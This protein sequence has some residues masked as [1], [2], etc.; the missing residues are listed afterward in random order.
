[1][2]T[3]E[4]LGSTK[5][6]LAL[7][8]N[9]DLLA[10]PPLQVTN[11]ARLLGTPPPPQHFVE[12]LLGGPSAY[13]TVA[14]PDHASAWLLGNP[15]DGSDTKV[16]RTPATAVDSATLPLL[17]RTLTD[18]NSYS[19]LAENGCPADYGVRL[20][21]AKGADNVEILWAADCD[22]LQITHEGHTTEKD[23]DA[24]RVALIQAFKAIFPTDATINK[25]SLLNPNQSK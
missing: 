9:S 20:Q 11:A 17:S 19:W 4:I 15:A 13:D 10:A 22:H 25:L 24:A 21:F 16:N 7:R 23:C 5:Q 8:I 14:H 6:C 1:V 18:F 3:I 2:A 12:E